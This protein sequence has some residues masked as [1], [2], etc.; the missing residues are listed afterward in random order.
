MLTGAYLLTGHDGPYALERFTYGPDATGWRYRATRHDPQTQTH[1]GELELVVAPDG[2][3]LRL[4]QRGGGWLL[5]GGVVGGDVL[6][7]RGDQ[8]HVVAAH[9]FTG[10]SP[11]Y[12]I[13]CSRLVGSRGDGALRLIAVHDD[14]LATATVDQVWTQA[15]DTW[16]CVDRSTGEAGRWV[17]DGDRVLSGPG[18]TIATP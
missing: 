17:L 3:V 9:G 18:V 14:A 1:L 2:R 10:S 12:A 13:V 16:T 11:A 4:E 5:R 6:W 8:E 15:G 7:R